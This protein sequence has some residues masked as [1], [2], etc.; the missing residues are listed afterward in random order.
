MELSDFSYSSVSPIKANIFGEKFLYNVNRDSFSR[1]SA[2]TIFD[3]EFSV[4]LFNED[5][6]YIIIG[7]DSGLLPKYIGE[8]GVPVGTRYIFI[9]LDN[10]FEELVQY[11]LL[12]GLPGEIV[13]TTLKNWLEE[14]EK[15]KL[16][17]YSYLRH[18]HLMKAVC[19]QHVSIAD[20]AELNWQ[21]TESLQSLHFQYTCNLGA[22][23]FIIRQIVNVADNVFP[24]KLLRNI[25]PG[26]TAIVLAGGPSL[27]EI[28]PWVKENRSKLIV[29]SVSRI[30]KILLSKDIEPDFVVAVDPQPENI[31]VSKEMFFFR[32]SIFIHSYHVDSSLVNQWAGIKFYLG[33]K[34]PW[35]AKENIDNIQSVGSTVSN[36]A[37]ATAHAFGCKRVL[38]AGVD[39]CFSKEGITHTVGTDEAAI[40]PDYNNT[41]SLELETYGGDKRTSDPDF[42]IALRSLEN[43]A[44]A[45]N[46]QDKEVINLSLGA[47]K[48]EGIRYMQPDEI[49]LDPEPFDPIAI[50]LHHIPEFTKERETVI[51][52]DAI[53]ELEKAIH[54]IKIIKKQ[55]TKALKINQEMYS[56]DGKIEKLKD[57]R[58]LDEIEK[59]LSKQYRTFS[60][61]VKNF[62]VLSFIRI[63]SPHDSSDSWDAEKAKKVGKIYYESY[64]YG[65]GKL[66]ILLDEAVARIRNRLEELQEKPNDVRS[67]IEQ[68]KKDKSYNRASIWL[69]RHPDFDLSQELR[70][71]FDQLDSEFRNILNSTN[72]N[73]KK[74]L[75]QRSS[76]G[77]LKTK[78]VILFRHNKKSE[79][80]NLL[81]G[82][83]LHHATEEEKNPY[84]QL[85]CAYIAELDNQFDE[86]ISYYDAIINDESQLLLEDALQRI[87][88]ISIKQRDHSNALLAFKCLSQISPMYLPFFA[89]SSRLTG[90]IVEAIDSY[91][92]Y[93]EFFPDDVVTQLKL[94]NL[95]IGIKVYEAAEMMLDHILAVNPDVHAAIQL[96]RQ[97]T[98]LKMTKD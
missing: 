25:Y 12:D 70:L 75:E 97:V 38:L 35:K 82:L 72:T 67:I 22:Q 8:R 91:N 14:A 30:S 47:A 65:A 92:E 89:E 10:I 61:L 88:A 49:N 20:Y 51:Q 90:N 60:N 45:I 11:A 36:S 31:D 26:R 29:F 21:I 27:Y 81:R 18:V 34:F 9:E 5:S 2:K 98:Q 7:T 71:E 19:A 54:Q 32:K 53:T 95:Y 79:L 24:A 46:E 74:N 37:L 80:V 87:A 73:F 48:A 23:S 93:I 15:L 6:L 63:T 41:S 76:L 57:K 94:A 77:L 16:R 44:K 86:A 62:S 68:W 52:K 69:D 17:D 64:L 33:N 96:K 78:A 3:D 55:A 40:G 42:Y 28:L 85:I 1:V 13:C 50:A 83:E 56:A 39:L 58:A 66:L 4:K 43:Q 84:T 59:R